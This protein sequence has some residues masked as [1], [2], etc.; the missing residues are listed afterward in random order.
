MQCNWA[1]AHCGC[2]EPGVSDGRVEINYKD[3]ME[4]CGDDRYVYHL[5]RGNVFM[6]I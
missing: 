1:K 3:H 2:L 4:I 6:G 5:N